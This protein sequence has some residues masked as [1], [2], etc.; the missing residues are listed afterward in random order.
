MKIKRII[1][2]ILI[3]FLVT[4]LIAFPFGFIKGW[5][6]R[7]SSPIPN[8]LDS[9]QGICAI[10]GSII[11]FSRLA[12]IQTNKTSGTLIIV[13]LASWIISFFTNVV[14]MNQN[15]FQWF[16]GIIPI[17]IS[18]VVGYFIGTKLYNRKKFS[19]IDNTEYNI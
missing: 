4:G 6:K 8:W 18:I 3:L 9:C 14:M 5:M 7:A 13:G 15:I 2:Y 1:I 12:Y 16:W 19:K 17:L 10:I 11:V